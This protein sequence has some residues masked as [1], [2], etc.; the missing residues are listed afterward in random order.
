MK[1]SKSG[2]GRLLTVTIIFFTIM[3][4]MS[5]TASASNSVSKK[6]EEVFAKWITTQKIREDVNFNELVKK[7]Y[8][9]F[10]EH[11]VRHIPPGILPQL[12]FM[13]PRTSLYSDMKE[14]EIKTLTS[15]VKTLQGFLENNVPGF[16]DFLIKNK[17]TS[18]GINFREEKEISEYGG[19]NIN[20]KYRLFAETL[21]HSEDFDELDSN[22]N[23]IANR[24]FEYCFYPDTF[25]HFEKVVS[26][27]NNHPLVRL[28][29]EVIWYY[30]ARGE[31]KSWHRNTLD[32]LKKEYDSGK[33]IV[34]IAGGDDIFQLISNGIYRIRN[35]DPIYPTQTRYYAEGWDFLAVGKD[36]GHGLN[37]RIVFTD[38][39][40]VARKIVM[41]RLS[42]HKQGVLLRTEHIKGERVTVPR[43]ITVWSIEE[44]NGRQLGTYTLERRFVEQDDFKP[45]PERALLMSFNEFYF[46]MTTDESNWGID[47]HLFDKDLALHIKQLRAPVNHSV[48]MNIRKIQESDFPNRF[49][50]S[51]VND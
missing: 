39:V 29:Y 24:F 26:S 36:G 11:F 42:Y 44:K 9:Q 23:S 4:F 21:L 25:K 32:N 43:S 33:E 50:S 45:D 1:F 15:Q 7:T 13:F 27:E 3:I 31:W 16:V 41:R 22:L 2:V 38:K 14:D 49:G 51:V 48:L 12:T 35:I 40:N 17:F 28:L 34:Y 8:P 19:T 20:T 18:A 46:I 10:I 37:D 6:S 30:L 47:P 5:K